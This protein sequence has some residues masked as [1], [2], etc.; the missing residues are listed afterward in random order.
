MAQEIP[1]IK[2][3]HTVSIEKKNHMRRRRS[4]MKENIFSEVGNE[5]NVF[6]KSLCYVS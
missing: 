3:N 4:H 1:R 6:V 5:E 2:H